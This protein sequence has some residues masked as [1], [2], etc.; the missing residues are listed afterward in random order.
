MRKADV[1]TN[2]LAGR[3]L[4][5]AG[6]G[7]V[8]ILFL[9][10]FVNVSCTVESAT[11]ESTFTGIDLVVGGTPNLSGPGVNAEF[12]Q[13]V[14]AL[15]ADELKTDVWALLS[16]ILVM[17]G[18]I[19]GLLRD[20]IGRFGVSAVLA[21]LAAALA[22]VA[23]FS[24]PGRA[25]TIRRV[26]SEQDI[27]VTVTVRPAYGFW[28]A[29]GTLAVL[30]VGSVVAVAQERRRPKQEP[31]NEPDEYADE[32]AEEYGEYDDTGPGGLDVITDSPR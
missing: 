8:L 25:E 26:F 30:T 32:Y 14:D 9:L 7:L 2:T 11:V 16:A 29:L 5:P 4:S 19:A 17:F 23:V 21:G 1:K 10:P 6:F 28:L 27:P 31:E 22:S 20:R 24:A 18:M 12:V 3:L 15:F 13:E